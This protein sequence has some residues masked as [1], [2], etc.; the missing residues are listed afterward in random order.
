MPDQSEY[1]SSRAGF[2]FA[3]QVA[4]NVL[5]PLAAFGLAIFGGSV[6]QASL[7]ADEL[8]LRGSIRRVLSIVLGCVASVGIAAASLAPFVL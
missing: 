8:R 5:L 1:W 4:S 2:I 7:R 3:D 6:V